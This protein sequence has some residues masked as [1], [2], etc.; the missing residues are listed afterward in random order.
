MLNRALDLEIAENGRVEARAGLL[1]TVGGSYRITETQDDRADQTEV[2]RV[3][4]IYYDLSLYQPLFFWGERRNNA[5]IGVIA[6]QMAEGNYR[7]AYRQ[8]AQQLR[9]GFGNL[10]VQKVALARA[11]RYM[12][13]AR[14]Q[15]AI[16]EAR[17]AKKEISDLDAFPVR[18]AAERGQ[19]ALEQSEFDFEN[20]KQS[21]A[22]LAG[23]ATITDSQIPDEIPAVP[24][25]AEAFDQLLA[26]FLGAKENPNADVVNQRRQVEVNQLSY[27]NQQTRLRPKVSAVMGASQDE[28]AYSINASQKYRVDSRYVGVQIMWSIFDGFASNAA[29]RSALAR[30]R[31][32]ENDLAEISDRVQRQAQTQVRYINFAARSMSISDR[33]L[34]SGHGALRAKQDEFKRG[35]ASEADVSMAELSLFDA[36]IAA[37]SAR[38]DLMLKIGEFLG[39]LNQDPVVAL[40]PKQ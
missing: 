16:A 39:T 7:E 1:P 37:Y 29:T 18:L 12:V 17:L 35:I 5:R 6:K 30:R 32:A 34:D 36:R 10:V 31:Q 25:S 27:R 9:G 4:K 23:I 15:V 19:I 13:Y 28:Q 26:G 38:L 20:A 24:Y 21:F 3:K 40:L 2:L 33:G 8:L 11:Q 22:R 14:Q